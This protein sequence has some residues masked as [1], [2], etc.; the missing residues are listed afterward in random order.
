MIANGE[1]LSQEFN[2]VQ[3]SRKPKDIRLEKEEEEGKAALI[4]TAAPSFP[5]VRHY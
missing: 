4:P 5:E 1:Q 2:I 3:I